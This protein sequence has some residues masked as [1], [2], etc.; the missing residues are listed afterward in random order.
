M[1]RKFNLFNLFNPSKDGRGVSKEEANAPRNFPYF[2]KMFFRNIGNLFYINLFMVLGNFPIFF[3]MIGAAGYFNKHGTAPASQLYG[4]FYGALTHQT[5]GGSPVTAALFGV[6]GISASVSIETPVTYVFYALTALLIF[7][8]GFVNV[9]TTYQLRNIVKGE[10]AFLW[11]DF[12]HA[13]KRNKKQ[14]FLM[15]ILDVA[16]LVLLVYDI[17]FF[18]YNIGAFLN[19]VLFYLSLV[20][21]VVYLIMRFYL[22]IIL[23]TF[24]LPLRKI[25]KNALIF[26]IIGFKRNLAAVVGIAAVLFFNYALFLA[27]LPL[28][29]LLPFII[30]IS[31]CSF[32]A[33]YAAFPKI[34]EL[35]I[36]PYYTEEE[37]VKEEPIFHDRG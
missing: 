36:D 1:A 21:A 15:G 10:P 16:L 29:I 33:A 12:W 8:F 23:V 5:A 9:G 17:L 27:F 19:N 13:I 32:I 30:T 31:A 6:H 34:K 2:F 18:Y 7:T 3:S 20:I 28:G 37:T 24:D 26:S 14:G 11:S 25:L 22:Y 4:P 35:M